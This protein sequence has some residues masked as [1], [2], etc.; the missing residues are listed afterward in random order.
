MGALKAVDAVVVSLSGYSLLASLKGG[1]LIAYVPLQVAANSID[2]LTVCLATLCIIGFSLLTIRLVAGKTEERIF[3]TWDCGF[4][5]LN[6][7]MQYSAT[8]FSKPLRIVFRILYR[9]GRALEVEEGASVY[10]PASMRYTVSTE[11]IF[12]TYIYR[13]LLRWVQKISLITKFSIQT[14][15]IHLYLTYIFLT[16]MLLMLYNQFA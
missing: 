13:P 5:S 6:A 16:L 14:G 3:G 9:P 8:G 12:E 2:S 10:F 1:F 4:S 11:P 7:R 15:S